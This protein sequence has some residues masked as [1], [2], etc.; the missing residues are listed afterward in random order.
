MTGVF[1]LFGYLL[2]ASHAQSRPVVL[3]TEPV[4]RPGLMRR[5][6]RRISQPDPRFGSAAVLFQRGRAEAV[7]LPHTGGPCDNTLRALE[8][9]GFIDQPE[10]RA[11]L[12]AALDAVSAC[13]AQHHLT[14]PPFVETFG[15][16]FALRRDHLTASIPHEGPSIVVYSEPG[17]ELFVDGMSFKKDALPWSGGDVYWTTTDHEGRPLPGGSVRLALGRG[18]RCY[19]PERGRI[20]VIDAMRAF[21]ETGHSEELTTWTELYADLIDAP[22]YLVSPKPLRVW[23]WCGPEEGLVLQQRRSRTACAP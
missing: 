9:L 22:L 19:L 13:A 3:S 17:I 16:P 20:G 6:S 18:S 12:L 1:L 23:E 15:D 8:Q 11:P 14:Q 10:E 4:A 21:E 2:S 5:V 7:Y